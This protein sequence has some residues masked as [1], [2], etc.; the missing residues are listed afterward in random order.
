MRTLRGQSAA[1]PAKP[2]SA[3]ESSERLRQLVSGKLPED[4]LVKALAALAPRLPA[5][6]T[7]GLEW[8]AAGFG[9]RS[10]GLLRSAVGGVSPA[11][12]ASAGGSATAAALVP[13]GAVAGILVDGDLRMAVTG[14]VSDRSGDEVLAFG[15]PFLDSGPVL[16]PMAAAEIVT[17]LASQYSSF[18]LASFGEPIGAF[19]E[20]RSVGVH[21]RIGLVAPTVPMSVM[22]GERRFQMRLA[23]V[24][25]LLP[26]LMAISAMGCLDSAGHVAGPQGYDLDLRL[27]TREHGELRLRQSFDGEQAAPQSATYLAAVA[28]FLADNPLAEVELDEISVEFAPSEKPRTAAITGAHADR[29]LVRPGEE[30]TV[31]VDFLAY[32]G[33]PFRRTLP[34][35][36]PA[37]VPN[38]RYSLF[39]GDGG[40]IDAVRFG[41]EPAA[42]HTF[43]QAMDLLR[44]LHSR[45]ELVALG[46][47]AGRGLAVA[48]RVMPRLPGSVRSL[49]SAAGSGS[50]VPLR[51]AI[52]QQVVEALDLPAEG[53]VRIDLEVRRREPQ[54]PAGA[55]PPTERVDTPAGSP[56]TPVKK[57]GGR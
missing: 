46:V 54:A 32:R 38:G 51:T 10:L 48:G 56:E 24:P 18:K 11:G 5:G 20:D 9:E 2:V 40:T 12:Q 19:D 47:S 37:D 39:V 21:G 3:D 17:V 50:A 1:A 25:Q 55:S 43:A 52:A 23:A 36:I 33:A 7:S 41:L 34:L 42:P 14:T 26:A 8:S 6:A 45:R 35:T 53:G 27:R 29:T 30:V 49:W 31:N 57:G 22:V 4:T 13:G 16:L 28:S 15:H 44:S